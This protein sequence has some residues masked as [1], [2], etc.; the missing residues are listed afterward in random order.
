M[1]PTAAVAWVPKVPTMAV[2]IYCTAVCISSSSMVGHASA[3]MTDSIFLSKRLLIF[4]FFF[5]SL[6][7]LVKNHYSTV[8]R[9]FVKI[10]LMCFRFFL[11]MPENRCPEHRLSI[12]QQQMG[13]RLQIAALLPQEAEFPQSF[14]NEHQEITLARGDLQKELNGHSLPAL[15]LRNLFHDEYAAAPEFSP[16]KMP[17]MQ[18]HRCISLSSAPLPSA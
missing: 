3:K 2:S 5:P 15:P 14:P 12:L 13:Q 7:F 11:K 4:L 9:G 17:W 10:N 8:P 18:K 6:G 16:P 1:A